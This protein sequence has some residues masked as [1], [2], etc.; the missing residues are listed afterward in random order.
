[1]LLPEE[2]YLSVIV[3]IN[4]ALPDFFGNGEATPRIESLSVA[5]PTDAGGSFI[6]SN[7]SS[8]LFG[9]AE[10]PPTKSGADNKNP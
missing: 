6:G 5:K 4:L 10:A 9:A 3:Q 7:L 8:T 2:I 1:L